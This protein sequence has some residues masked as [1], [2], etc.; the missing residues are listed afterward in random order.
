M[1]NLLHPGVY[2]TDRDD[3]APY[4]AAL[5]D[6]KVSWIGSILD[7]ARA[8]LVGFQEVFSYE[9]IKSVHRAFPGKAALIFRKK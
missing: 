8:D 6:Q 2:Y 7:E 5:F 9:A 4:D 1:E 3:S